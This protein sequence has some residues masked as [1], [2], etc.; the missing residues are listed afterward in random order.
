M[1]KILFAALGIIMSAVCVWTQAQEVFQARPSNVNNDHP[2]TSFIHSN[3][4]TIWYSTNAGDCAN[5]TTAQANT[6]LNELEL[7]Y[8]TFIHRDSFPAPYAV[9]A[10]KYKMGV[11]V[12]R[13]GSNC[14]N[15]V[16]TRFCGGTSTC[17]EGHAFGGTIG[18]P[19]GPGMWLSSSAVGDKWALAHELMHGLQGMTGGM[20]GGNTN[21]GANFSGWFWESH[22]NLTPHQVYPS[23]NDIHY[24]SE[25]YLRQSNRY[26]GSTRN[27]YCNWLFFEYIQDTLGLGVVNN[28]WAKS[29]GQSQADPMSEIMRQNNISQTQF[30]NYFGDFARKAVIYDFKRGAGFRSRY[31]AGSVS[32]RFKYS[33]YTRL[34]PLDTA[35]NRY[36]SAFHTSPQRYAYNIIRLYPDAGGNFSAGTTVTVKF[37]GDVQTANNITNYTRTNNTPEPTAA[38]LPNNPGSDWRYSLVAVTGDAASTSASVAARYSD[39]NSTANGIG[40]DITMTMQNGETQLYLVVAATPAI[41][42]RINWDQPYFTIYRFPYMVEINGAK[43]E[44]FQ[45]KSTTNMTQHANGGGWRA[46]TA[47]VASTAYIGPYA[48]VESGTVSGNARIE[49]RAVVRGSSTVSGNAIVRGNALVVGGTVTDSAIISENASVW[50]GRY[51]GGARIDGGVNIHLSNSAGVSGSGRIGGGDSWTEGN[52]VALNVS[53]TAQIVGDGELYGITI[54]SGVK[55]GIVDNA[56]ANKSSLPTEV[57]KPRSMQWYDGTVSAAQAPKIKTAK[58][59][60]FDNRGV[61]HYNLGGP[62]ASAKLTFFDIR[63]RVLNSVP[64]NG[65]QGKIDARVNMGSQVMFWKIEN[66]GGVVGQGKIGV[67]R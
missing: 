54:S 37:R 7:I 58:R 59:F 56:T 8:E 36:V 3:R 34:E 61:L 17:S 11:W 42:H 18:N 62:D 19:R 33:R 13:N 38:N 10:T 14:S 64:L 46:N 30:N 45:T 1:K 29:S 52:N 66:D 16:G 24:C 63:G 39:L 35:N 67:V 51:S 26:L 44:G 21:Q 60:T 43:P 40:N 55:Y 41:H 22:A 4:F 20:S 31:N 5:L 15:T 65:Q 50:S 2:W 57:T 6:A 27:R 28:I 9:N 48:R 49:D 47:T 25:M 12:L 32:E 53:G 23:A